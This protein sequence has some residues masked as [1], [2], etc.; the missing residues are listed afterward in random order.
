MQVLERFFSKPKTQEEKDFEYARAISAKFSTPLKRKKALVD[1]IGILAIKQ[2]LEENGFEVAMS[3]VDLVA[4]NYVDLDDNQMTSF[5][6]LVAALEELDDVQ[7]VYHN[8]NLP[9]EQE[10]E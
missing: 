2:Y 8:V 10:E 7:N 5:N 9:E 6:K 1:V 3:N 4:S